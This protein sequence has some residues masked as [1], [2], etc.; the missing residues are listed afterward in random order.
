MRITTCK[1]VLGHRRI[2]KAVFT[3]PRLNQLHGNTRKRNTYNMVVGIWFVWQHQ[4]FGWSFDLFGKSVFCDLPILAN[5]KLEY[6]TNPQID[7]VMFGYR[8][9]SLTGLSIY[10]SKR[11]KCWSRRFEGW[12]CSNWWTYVAVLKNQTRSW[13]SPQIQK[14]QSFTQ[15]NNS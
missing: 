12:V 14:K 13:F 15:F 3:S 2:G 11:R 4:F 6:F 5:I 8:C 10:F 1:Q 7:K 9:S